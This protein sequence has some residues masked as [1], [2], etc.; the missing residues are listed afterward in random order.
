MVYF[1]KIYKIFVILKSIISLSRG[2]FFSKSS[3]EKMYDQN[4]LETILLHSAQLLYYILILFKILAYLMKQNLKFSHL[5][6]E[7]SHQFLHFCL[8]ILS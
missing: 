4:S 5:N 3:L 6:F 8:L 1:G 7:K 2:F